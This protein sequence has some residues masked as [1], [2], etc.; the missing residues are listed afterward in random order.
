VEIELRTGETLHWACDVMLA[1]PARP[2]TQEQH[3]LKFSRCLE[4]ARDPLPGGMALVDLV[5]RLE[6]VADVRELCA[7]LAPR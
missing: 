6:E 5:D 7:L 2:L 3:V 1:N 4:F